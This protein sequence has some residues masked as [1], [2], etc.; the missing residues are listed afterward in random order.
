MT[1]TDFS[2]WKSSTRPVSTQTLRLSASPSRNSSLPAGRRRTTTFLATA[3]RL[4]F[5]MLS[6]GTRLRSCLGSIG[7]SSVIGVLPR[8]ERGLR[9]TLR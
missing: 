8:A 6:N 9:S 4:S 2:P 5:L 7:L 1:P 3:A